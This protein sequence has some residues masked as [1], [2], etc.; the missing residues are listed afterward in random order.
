MASVPTLRIN[1]KRP[2][3]RCI[4]QL[5]KTKDKENLERSRKRGNSFCTEPSIIISS[6][7]LMRNPGVQQKWDD[8]VQV[9]KQA[10]NQLAVNQKSCIW[11]SCPQNERENLTTKLRKQMRMDFPISGAILQEMINQ[12]FGWE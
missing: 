7:L 6:R 11:E 4:F 9:L 10:A 3:L 2:T 1:S 8:V 12:T 5:R